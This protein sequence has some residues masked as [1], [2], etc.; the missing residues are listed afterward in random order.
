LLERRSGVRPVGD[1]PIEAAIWYAVGA[2]IATVLQMM[3]MMMMLP[4]K[5]CRDGR[6]LGHRGA[7]ESSGAGRTESDTSNPHPCESCG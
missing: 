6:Q 4:G 1:D 5:L 7:L 3:T 2:D